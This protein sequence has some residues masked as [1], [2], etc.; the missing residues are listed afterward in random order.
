MIFTGHCR[1]S[2]TTLSNGEGNKFTLENVY[3]KLKPLINVWPSK[4]LFYNCRAAGNTEDVKDNNE[5]E[6]RKNSFCAKF[7]SNIYKDNKTIK[8]NNI[9][10][11]CFGMPV[12]RYKQTDFFTNK[13]KLIKFKMEG[14]DI[15]YETQVDDIYIMQLLELLIAE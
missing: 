7:L 5:D 11:Y 13:N 1:F 14:N 10:A 2:D 6:I 8:D 4:I 3:E 15:K 12:K 9:T